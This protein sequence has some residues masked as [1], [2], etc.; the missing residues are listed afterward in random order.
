MILKNYN[1]I[2][3]LFI[4]NRVFTSMLGK[5]KSLNE[6]KNYLLEKNIHNI[7]ETEFCQGHTMRWGIAW[8]FSETQLPIFNYLKVNYKK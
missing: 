3:I 7:S 6:L 1:L 8:S 5:K 4:I 2:Q